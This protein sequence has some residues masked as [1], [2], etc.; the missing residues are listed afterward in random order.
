M[1]ALQPRPE[2][3]PA[4]LSRLTTRGGS[5]KVMAEAPGLMAR[6]AARGR[7]PGLSHLVAVARDAFGEAPLLRGAS[8]HAVEELSASAREVRLEAREWLFREGDTADQL[9]VVLSGAAAG[10]RG[11]RRTAA[12]RGRTGGGARRARPADRVRAV[13]VRARRSGQPA[14]GDRRRELHPPARGRRHLRSFRCARARPPA[15]GERRAGA[16]RDEAVRVRDRRCGLG[17]RRRLRGRALERAATLRQR[18]LARRARACAGGLRRHARAGRGASSRTCCCSTATAHGAASVGASP[19]ACSS[20]RAATPRRPAIPRSSAASSCS[21]ASPRAAS[22]AGSTPSARA[23]HHIVSAAEP[24]TTGAAR[25]ARRITQR[26]LG[27][28]LS[29]GGARGFAHIGALAALAEAGFEFD[30]VGGCSMGSFIAAMGAHRPLGGGDR[31]ALPRGARPPL[32][33]QRLHAAAG[34]PDPVAQGDRDARARVRRRADRGERRSRF[35]VSADL[36]IEQRRRPPPRAGSRTPS[37][38][39]CR[40]P[41]IA[42]PFRQAGRLL[43]DGGVLN[44]LPIDHMA[45]VAEGRSSRST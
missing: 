33:V 5:S 24:R 28:V 23:R 18:R 4:G 10:G 8:P 43:V 26:S 32:A 25:V 34:L 38:R 29:G 41:G 30:R 13:G 11:G 17:L 2:G 7:P 1:A 40:F 44:N 39:A 21:T 14:A 37:R 3:D 9:F 27:L 16:A 12:A 42:P 6:V 31:G 36:L 22:Q 20:S 35:T 45:E 19:T 15:P